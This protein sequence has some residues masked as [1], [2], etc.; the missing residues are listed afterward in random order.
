MR[1][2]E[3]LQ[4]P[5]LEGAEQSPLV[6]QPMAAT[7]APGQLGTTSNHSVPSCQTLAFWGPSSITIK[8]PKVHQNKWTLMMRITALMSSMCSLSLHVIDM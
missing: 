5:A 3:G 1:K 4:W 2:E 6:K 7:V 8:Q